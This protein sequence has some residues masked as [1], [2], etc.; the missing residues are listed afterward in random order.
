MMRYLKKGNFVGIDPN[1]W[2]RER[3][4]KDPEVFDL[5][6]NKQA[7][8]LSVDDFDASALGIKFDLVFSHS[9]LSH[10]AHWQLLQFLRNTSKVLKP[11][12][13]MVASLVLAEKDSMFKEWQYPTGSCFSHST[14]VSA[15]NDF[16]LRATLVP[17]HTKFY[18]ATR[19]K[20][21]HDW[22]VFTWSAEGQGC[23]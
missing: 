13:R 3:V 5:V 16:G 15:A 18:T 4:M 8:F 22:F 6:E 20:E 9:V 21:I 7:R 23:L 12:G 19:P 11:S 2:L 10:A 17:E 1:A 14:L